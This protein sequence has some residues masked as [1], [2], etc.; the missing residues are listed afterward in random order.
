M[1]GARRLRFRAF[2]IGSVDS[3][4]L[5]IPARRA[6]YSLTES[7]LS[8][9]QAEPIQ[10]RADYQRQY[11]PLLYGWRQGA[12]R[13]WCGARDQGDVWFFDK[14]RV[15][16]LHPTMKPVELIERAITNSSRSGDTVLDP[17]SGSGSTVIACEKT[18]PKGRL[19]ELDPIYVDVSVRRW[20][21][22][23]G[24]IARRAADGRTFDDV[25]AERSDGREIRG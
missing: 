20:Q 12:E 9:F 4:A 1:N 11:E 10:G 6:E 16:D 18:D 25:S 19:I 8:P 13:H 24:R 3:D 17:F 21:H 22:F 2:H 15:N 5:K 7:A 23:T 14:P